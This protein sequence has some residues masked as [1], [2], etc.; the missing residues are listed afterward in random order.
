M[1]T[2][3]LG[4]GTGGVGR[5]SGFPW[6]KPAGGRSVPCGG[7]KRKGVPEGVGRVSV[8]GLKVVEPA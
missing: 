2:G 8:R 3:V 7:E 1:M 5:N 4:E 6:A